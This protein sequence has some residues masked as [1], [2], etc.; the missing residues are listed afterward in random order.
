MIQSNPDN[1]K[2]SSCHGEANAMERT[3]KQHKSYTRMNIRCNKTSTKR[4]SCAGKYPRSQLGF[5]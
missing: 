4:E 1:N 5:F 3:Y 2:Q